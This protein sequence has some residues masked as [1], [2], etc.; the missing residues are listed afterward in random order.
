MGAVPSFL[1]SG[2]NGLASLS[3]GAFIKLEAGKPVSV[4]MLTGVNAPKGEEANGKNSIISF[5]QYAIWMEQD[6]LPEGARSPVFPALGGK[7]DPGVMLGLDARFRALA[8]VKVVGEEDGDEKILGIGASLFKQ[9]VEIEQAMGESLKGAI[10]RINRTGSGL[11]TK[12]TATASGKRVTIQ[13]EPEL[14]LT[15]HVGPTSRDAIVEML[16]AAG[17]WP[18]PGGDPFANKVE[19]KSGTKIETTVPAGR[20]G[21]KKAEEVAPV[22]DE[23]PPFAVADT[24]ADAEDDYEQA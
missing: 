12:Y 22:G 4:I 5:N 9:L 10:I 14:D 8:L 1:K 3:G 7:S 19:V 2:E 16:S 6:E 23:K 17:K 20:K 11:T 15:E 18:P 21:A 13:G 24:N